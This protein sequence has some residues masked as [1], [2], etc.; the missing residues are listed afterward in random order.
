MARIS[1]N[2]TVLELAKKRAREKTICLVQELE[3]E[4]EAERQKNGSFT[5]DELA[6]TSFNFPSFLGII[7]R[8]NVVDWSALDVPGRNPIE[9]GE[10]SR[11]ATQVP[12]YFLLMSSLSI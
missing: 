10:S 3:E 6:E 8:S 12:I 2:K 5:N 1:R 7:D 4:E 11:G 9:T